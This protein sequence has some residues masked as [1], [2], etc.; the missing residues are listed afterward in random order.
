MHWPMFERT[1]E[2]RWEYIHRKCAWA[3]DLRTRSS[4]LV[5]RRK[6]TRDTEKEMWRRSCCWKGSND[7]WPRTDSKWWWAAELGKEPLDDDSIGFLGRT[8]VD[9]SRNFVGKKRL[10]WCQTN[11]PKIKKTIDRSKWRSSV[12]DCDDDGDDD[13]PS[14]TESVAVDDWLGRPHWTPILDC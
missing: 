8:I 14:K 1:T 10:T 11:E 13:E 2:F 6:R 12:D 5:A 7:E 9:A 4:W 3:I